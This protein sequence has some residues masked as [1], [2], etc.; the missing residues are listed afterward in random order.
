[1]CRVICVF[2]VVPWVGLEYV[3]M[4]VPAHA[5]LLCKIKQNFH[6]GLHCLQKYPLYKEFMPGSRKF[7]QRGSNSDNV[8]FFFFF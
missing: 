5:R 3:I 8:F 7:C 1:M 4:A 2:L 6:P